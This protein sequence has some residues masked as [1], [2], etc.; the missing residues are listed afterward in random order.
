MNAR[1]PE[2][3]EAMVRLKANGMTHEE[4]AAAMGVGSA[5]VKRTW[6]LKRETGSVSPKAAG[7]GWVSPLREVKESFVRLVAENADATKRELAELV[8]SQLKVETSASSV[9]RFLR[10]LGFTRKKRSS[11][12]RSE[13]ARTSSGAAT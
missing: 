7:G 4:I 1:S 12:R 11:L 2:E 13:T 5:T 9:G 3:R 8:K 10:A 6:R